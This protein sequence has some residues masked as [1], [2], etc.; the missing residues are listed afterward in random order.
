[1]ISALVT[2]CNGFRFRFITLQNS[3]HLFVRSCNKPTTKLTE[4]YKHPGSDVHVVRAQLAGWVKI[5]VR[6]GIVAVSV[7]IRVRL[8]LHI[9][10]MYVDPA[11]FNKSP[12][13][14]SH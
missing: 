7:W 8:G 6:V 1:M 12:T 9:M 2:G 4:T 13:F 3:Q 10:A 14:N 11:C 5:K